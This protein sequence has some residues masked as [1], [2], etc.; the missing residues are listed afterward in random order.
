MGWEPGEGAGSMTAADQRSQTKGSPPHE[1]QE[2]KR[3]T[4]HFPTGTTQ[5]W[6]KCRCVCPTPLGS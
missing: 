2:A 3:Q 6:H 5:V 4:V 1:A